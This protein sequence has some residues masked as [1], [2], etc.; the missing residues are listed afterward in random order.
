[1]LGHPLLERPE[2]ELQVGISNSS[3][4]IW[5]SRS[6]VRLGR[7]IGFQG[8]ALWEIAIVVSELIS[9]VV[10]FAGRGVLEVSTTAEGIRI[11]VEDEG[12]GIED[13][14]SA[15][16]DGFS[17]GRL[18]CEDDLVTGRRGLGSGLGAV[19]RLMDSVEI[20]NKPGGGVRVEAFKRLRS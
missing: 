16:Q 3:D 12:P 4:S 5:C 18:L 15:L 14:E 9:N 8:H 11:V 7:S 20:R 2:P 10:K 17:E 19:R 6:T 13:I 1:M